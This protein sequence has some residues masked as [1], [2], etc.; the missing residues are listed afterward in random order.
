MYLLVSTRRIVWILGWSALTVTIVS[1]DSRGSYYYVSVLAQEVCT[2][3]AVLRC[4]GHLTPVSEDQ[5]IARFRGG[6]IASSCVWT[7]KGEV[8]GWEKKKTTQA[9][10]PG[11][12]PSPRKSRISDFSGV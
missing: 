10:P 2:C 4:L 6:F 11:L 9:E 3:C 7:G 5:S 1:Q 8:R 12:W